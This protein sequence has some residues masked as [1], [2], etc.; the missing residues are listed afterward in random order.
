MAIKHFEIPFT[1]RVRIRSAMAHLGSLVWDSVEFAV[2]VRCV[3]WG[4]ESA[5]HVLAF[6]CVASNFIAC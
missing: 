5:N 1:S 2:S 3:L 6:L 4:G